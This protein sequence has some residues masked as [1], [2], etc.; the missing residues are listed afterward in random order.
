[1]TAF[2]PLV[3]TAPPSDILARGSRTLATRVNRF[4]LLARLSSEI[5]FQRVFRTACGRSNDACFTV[6]SATNGSADA[7]LGLAISKKKTPTSA[8]RN[9]LKRIVRESFRHHRK[10]LAGLDIVVMNNVGADKKSNAELFAALI[11]HWSR[12]TAQCNKSSSG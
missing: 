8:G 12:V 6:L 9:R 7:R 5:D 4:P 3:Y 10:D 1:M 2:G 11:N